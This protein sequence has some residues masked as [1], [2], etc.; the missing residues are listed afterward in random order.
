MNSVL[1]QLAA[2]FG[3]LMFIISL[4]IGLLSGVSPF[5]ALCR[6]FVVMCIST[7]IF[8]LFAGFF[9]KIVYSFILE[10]MREQQRKKAQE[11]AAAA[12]TAAASQPKEKAS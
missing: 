2:S 1:R 7:V 4:V 3:A 11:A 8:A 9:V 5:T 6:S 12:A 10:K